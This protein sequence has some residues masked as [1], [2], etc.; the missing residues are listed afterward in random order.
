MSI[1]RVKQT[2]KRVSVVV[3]RIH[4]VLAS[5]LAVRQGFSDCYVYVPLDTDTSLHSM[6]QTKAG[7]CY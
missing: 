7:L 6:K 4:T 5:L 1:H 2:N 3:M